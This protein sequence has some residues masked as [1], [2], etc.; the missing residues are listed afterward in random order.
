[1][2]SE[3]V[4]G[5]TLPLMN[6]RFTTQVNEKL[7][8]NLGITRGEIENALHQVR[9]LYLSHVTVL[10]NEY[11]CRNYNRAEIRKNKQHSSMLSAKYVH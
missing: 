1:M 8:L 7:V 5:M 2:V 6:I 4:L 11:L 10:R 3:R 9:I